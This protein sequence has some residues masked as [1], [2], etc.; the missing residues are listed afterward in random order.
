MK[1]IIVVALLLCFVTTAYGMSE[2]EK[3]YK[4]KLENINLD[5]G[6]SMPNEQFIANLNYESASSNYN[7]CIKEK[8]GIREADEKYNAKRKLLE[9]ENTLNEEMHSP[10]SPRRVEE[11]ERS[12]ERVEKETD[13]GQTETPN[14]DNYKRDMYRAEDKQDQLKRK[15]EALLKEKADLKIKVLEK[16][17]KL[18]RWWKQSEAQM[19]KYLKH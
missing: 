6:I 2:L 11:G 3:A 10:D 4:E 14:C 9:T 17:G 7:A 15:K 13:V 8:Q 5:L 1:Q 12:F 19:K 16:F 18:P